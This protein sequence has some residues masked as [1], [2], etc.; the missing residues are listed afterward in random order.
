MFF[1]GLSSTGSGWDGPGI[2]A[3]GIHSVT[4]YAVDTIPGVASLPGAT[5]ALGPGAAS[6]GGIITNVGS[7]SFFDGDAANLTGTLDGGSF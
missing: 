7:G 2:S 4:R 6:T 3:Y 5:G 1:D